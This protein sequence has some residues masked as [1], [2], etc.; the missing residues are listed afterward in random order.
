MAKILSGVRPAVGKVVDPVARTLLRVGVTPDAIT[1]AGTVGILVA[2]VL[3]ANDFIL[4]AVIL[5]TISALTDILDGAMARARGTS[6]RFGAFLDS[7]LDRVAD[8]AIFASLAWWA[9][10]DEAWHAVFAALVVLIASQVTSYVRAK[11]ESLGLTASNGVV[12]R[13]ERLLGIG[14]GGFAAG[15][16]WDVGMYIV[17][18]ILALLS[19]VTVVQRFHTVYKQ[20]RTE[21]SNGGVDG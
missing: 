4:V 2:S 16:G 10:R 9:A 18:W 12:E 14:V 20:T 3:A 5:A 11:A 13:P 19:V 7:S 15:F 6:S 8:G 17:L 1:V 21:P